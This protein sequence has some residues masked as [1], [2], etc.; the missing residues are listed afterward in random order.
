MTTVE[1]HAAHSAIAVLSPVRVSRVRAIRVLLV[2][3]E[4]TYRETLI[5]ELSRRGMAVRC[6]DGEPSLLGEPRFAVDADV[7]VAGWGMPKMS[8]L[9]L[10][11]RL[12]RHGVDVPLVLL[13]GRALQAGECLAFN[14]DA[15]K[16]IGKARGVEALARRLKVLVQ[17]VHA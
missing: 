13:A 9:A 8:G 10:W 1:R 6:V 11:G 16:F 15:G 4:K 5:D 2:E 12:R 7:I 3:P 17:G 14:P